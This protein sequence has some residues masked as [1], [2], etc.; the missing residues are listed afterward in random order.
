VENEHFDTLLPPAEKKKLSKCSGSGNVGFVVGIVALGQIFSENFGFPCQFAFHRLLHNH[1][2][3]SSW[4]GT[5]GQ[6]VAAVPNGLKSHP[7]R[8][9]KK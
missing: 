8:K 1:H 6:T 4:A 7:K 9:I 5:I 2:H 3:L